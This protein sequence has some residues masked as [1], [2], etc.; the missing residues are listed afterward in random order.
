MVSLQETCVLF[1]SAAEL[2]TEKQLMYEY[3]L[4][5]V[6]IILTVLLL[7]YKKGKFYFC[8]LVPTVS[9]LSNIEERFSFRFLVKLMTHHAASFGVAWDLVLK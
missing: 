5:A 1:V 9:D 8:K 2:P 7:F 4:S 6:L 3:L